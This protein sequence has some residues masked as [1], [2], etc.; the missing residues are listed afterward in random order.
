[1]VFP[2]L[3]RPRNSSFCTYR[4]Q[5]CSLQQSSACRWRTACLFIRPRLARTSQTAIAPVSACL[6]LALKHACDSRHLH[7]STSHIL[8]VAC[9]YELVYRKGRCDSPGLRWKELRVLT[10]IITNQVMS[11][12]KPSPPSSGKLPLV[13]RQPSNHHQST[14]NHHYRPSLSNSIPVHMH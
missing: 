4:Y 1:M 8:S 6:P 5:F 3:S 14:I 13:P 2:A 7:Q 10:T 11:T 12:L 9:D